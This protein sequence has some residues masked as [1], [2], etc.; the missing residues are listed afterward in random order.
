M[1]GLKVREVAIKLN[2]SEKTVY[3]WLNKGILPAG[4]IGKTWIIDEHSI[5]KLLSNS[6]GTNVDVSEDGLGKMLKKMIKLH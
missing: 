2:V 3:K 6:F 1:N 5:E 4:R